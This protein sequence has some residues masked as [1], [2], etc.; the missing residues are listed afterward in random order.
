MSVILVLSLVLLFVGQVQL[1]VTLTAS[2]VAFRIKSDGLNS[3][4]NRLIYL[5]IG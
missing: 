3:S 5:D 4:D 1:V 2:Y